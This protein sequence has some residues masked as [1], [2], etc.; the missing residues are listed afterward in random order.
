MPASFNIVI[1]A[2][3]RLS[4]EFDRFHSG[5]AKMPFG[6][7]KADEDEWNR[8]LGVSAGSQVAPGRPPLPEGKDSR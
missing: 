1:I 7:M 6:K 4:A 3:V 5:E 8:R 2:T